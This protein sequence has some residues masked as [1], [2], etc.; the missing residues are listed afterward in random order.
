MPSLV[1]KIAPSDLKGT[2]MGVYNTLQSIGVFTGGMIGSKMYASFGFQGVFA[3][4]SVMVGIWLLIAMTAPAP[5]PVKNVVLA[6]PEH[7]QSRLEELSGS[8]KN[9]AGV[10]EISFSQDKQNLFIKALQQ[11]FDEEQVKQI[12]LTGAK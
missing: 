5:K 12:L 11:G 6:L 7:W 1:S 10:E 2:A 3:F 4:C 8:L 9:V